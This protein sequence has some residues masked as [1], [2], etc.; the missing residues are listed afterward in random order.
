[1]KTQKSFWLACMSGQRS[2]AQ[3]LHLKSEQVMCNL[4][5]LTFMQVVDKNGVRI[6][7]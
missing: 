3:I 4:S 5:R 7:E 1:M 2:D 6:L